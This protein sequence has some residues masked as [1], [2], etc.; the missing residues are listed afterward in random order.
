[1]IDIKKPLFSKKTKKILLVFFA[2]AIGLTIQLH[3]D[4]VRAEKADNF[5]SRLGINQGL[6]PGRDPI[7]SPSQY[8]I[9][10]QG[11]IDLGIRNVRHNYDFWE[12]FDVEEAD[13]PNTA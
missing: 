1:M 5:V 13:D 7:I 3:A 12:H 10:R 8:S 11:L 4:V 6:A 9:I 2:S